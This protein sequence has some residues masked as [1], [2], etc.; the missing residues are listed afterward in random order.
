VPLQ[1]LNV[2]LLR[3][4]VSSKYLIASKWDWAA[5]AGMSSALRKRT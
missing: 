2:S 3:D 1:A 5:G 4:F